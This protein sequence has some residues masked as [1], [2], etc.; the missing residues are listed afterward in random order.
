[1]GAGTTHPAGLDRRFRASLARFA[2]GV[3][4][5]TFDGPGGRRGFTANSFISV[6]LDPPLVLVSVARKARSHDELVD[7]PFVVNVLGAEQEAMAMHFAGRPQL[8]PGWSDSPVGPRLDGALAH[9]ACEPWA[10]YDGGDHTLFVGRVVD[11]DYRQGDL[12]GFCGGSFVTI[13]EP[14]LGI[15]HLM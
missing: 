12:L 11:F 14:M 7:R 9:F 15:E 13:P 2:T 10:A 6:S 4:V 3:T 1:M 5:V 8:E